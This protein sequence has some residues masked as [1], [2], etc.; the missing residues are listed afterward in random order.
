[1]KVISDVKT[2]WFFKRINQVLFLLSLQED[3]PR[4]NENLFRQN[5]RNS[6]AERQG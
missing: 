2:V 4:V 6:L 5:P 3:L 1:M